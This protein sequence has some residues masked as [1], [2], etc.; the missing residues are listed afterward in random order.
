LRLLI[1]LVLIA[2]AVTALVV[3]V[4]PVVDR[5]VEPPEVTVQ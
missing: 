5:L 4:F 2:A 1:V 3:W